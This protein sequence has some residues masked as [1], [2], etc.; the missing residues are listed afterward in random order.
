MSVIWVVEDGQ[1]FPGGLSFGEQEFFGEGEQGTADGNVLF[2]Q[3]YLVGKGKIQMA[4]AYFIGDEVYPVAVRSL[5]NQEEEII[6]F[7]VR[8]EEFD[9][10][11]KSGS[12][13]LPDLEKTG[14]VCFPA[15]LLQGIGW[16]VIFLPKSIHDSLVDSI[17]LLR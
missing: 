14:P 7:P 8:E 13:D 12:V 2:F 16:N 5:F 11:L 3:M 4:G 6:F 1:F 10:A 15:V 9:A 17:R